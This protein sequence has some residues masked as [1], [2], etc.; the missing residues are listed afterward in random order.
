MIREASRVDLD[1]KSQTAY[2]SVKLNS[3]DRDEHM[4]L[5]SSFSDNLIAESQDTT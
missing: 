3:I 1:V 4:P 5:T 2:G